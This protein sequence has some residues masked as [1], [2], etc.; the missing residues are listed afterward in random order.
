LGYILL[1]VDKFQLHRIINKHVANDGVSVFFK[2]LTHIGDG[3]FA[4]GLVLILL[5][6]SVRKS[7]YVLISYAGSALLTT[8]LK[9]VFYADYYRPYFNFHFFAREQLNLVDGVEIL[10]N[11]SFPSGHATSAFAVFFCLLSLTKNHGL[12]IV[13]FVTALLA[14]FSRTYL[15]QHWL[16]DIYVG[17][18]I[19]VSFSVVCYVIFYNSHKWH[20]LN[21]SIFQ[22]LS[23]NKTKGV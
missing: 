18:I 12:K 13:C 5:F 19:G 23:K 22:L 14:A 20:Y 7:V 2:Y 10:S 17:S 1:T 6:F 3:I 16:V 21:T 4:I 9:N 11:N 15:S 8:L